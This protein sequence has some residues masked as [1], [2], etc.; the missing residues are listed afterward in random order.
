MIIDFDLICLNFIFR[1]SLLTPSKL[2]YVQALFITSN[3]P[4][5]IVILVLFV[6]TELQG[7]FRDY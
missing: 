2:Y 1:S 5:L 3:T 6:Y 4:H 7:N